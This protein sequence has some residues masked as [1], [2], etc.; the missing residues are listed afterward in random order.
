[1]IT[2]ART[3]LGKSTRQVPP[4]PPGSST[5]APTGTPTGTP[6]TGSSCCCRPPAVVENN[7]NLSTPQRLVAPVAPA[8][9]RLRSPPA[10]MVMNDS[11]ARVSRSSTTM[12]GS[13]LAAGSNANANSADDSGEPPLP[14]PS[15]FFT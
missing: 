4:V 11:G 14:C 13:A 3:P 10:A 1:M 5:G 8:A 7:L 9:P 2:V 6:P 15:I 12:S